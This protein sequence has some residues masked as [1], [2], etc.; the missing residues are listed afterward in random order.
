[1]QGPGAGGNVGPA[2][3]YTWSQ[4]KGWRQTGLLTKATRT[5]R[6]SR[7]PYTVLATCPMIDR[8]N[9]HHLLPCSLPS[10]WAQPVG[11]CLGSLK[12]RKVAR[13]WRVGCLACQRPTL[14]QTA[15]L[16][17][18]CHGSNQLQPNRSAPE[19]MTGSPPCNHRRASSFFKAGPRRREPRD[20][21]LK[22]TMR[23]NHFLF[24]CLPV[25]M[26]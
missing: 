17:G 16:R 12:G 10:I 19:R 21:P 1:M 18:C 8:Y 14:W 4:R 26:K 22:G 7:L 11:S 3:G 24:F 20:V 23:S 2:E 15:L 6:E 13:S 5:A 9:Q 25:A